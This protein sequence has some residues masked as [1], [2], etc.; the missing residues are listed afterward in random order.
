LADREFIASSVGDERLIQGMIQ[1]IAYQSLLPGECDATAGNQHG[2]TYYLPPLAMSRFAPNIPETRAIQQTLA[3]GGAKTSLATDLQFT[4]A[5]TA[6]ISVPAMASLEVAGWSL[7]RFRTQEHQ[8][9]AR[10]AAT[11]ALQV[12]CA[13]HRE[14]FRPVLHRLMAAAGVKAI[15]YA[16]LVAPF[17][18]ERELAFHFTKVRAQTRL[19]IENYRNRGSAEGIATPALDSLSQS[20][21]F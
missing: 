9:P 14:K 2:V 11:E 1:F 20:L 15:A 21:R 3:R 10:R 8:Q 17:P 7:G 5:V 13:Y 12:S 16:P 18:V 4:Y 6:A 19:M